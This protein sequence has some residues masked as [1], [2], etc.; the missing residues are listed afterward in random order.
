M[1]KIISAVR[2]IVLAIIREARLYFM[3]ILQCSF[4]RCALTGSP[5]KVVQ[6]GDGIIS[7]SNL[8]DSHNCFFGKWV[9]I[10]GGKSFFHDNVSNPVITL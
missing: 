7:F 2:K 9:A 10:S 5:P 8:A 4:K 6:R 3:L 1:Q